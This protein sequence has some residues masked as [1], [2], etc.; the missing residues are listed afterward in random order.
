M[1]VMDKAVTNIAVAD[2]DDVVIELA[3]IFHL[4]GDPMRLRI[5]LCCL[6]G[7][8]AVGDIAASVGASTALTSHHLRLLKAARLVRFRKQ[9]KQIFYTLSDHHVRHMIED[10]RDHI[11][12]PDHD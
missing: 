2:D 8:A 1:F 9:G 6:A 7:E 4:L 12:E 10:M 3:E 5:V 11:R